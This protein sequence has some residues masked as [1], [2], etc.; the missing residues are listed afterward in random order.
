MI[1]FACLAYFTTSA[2]R[3]ELSNPYLVTRLRMNGDMP[4]LPICL[5]D[6]HTDNINFTFW[7]VTNNS[8]AYNRDTNNN[9]LRYES[10]NE[11]PLSNSKE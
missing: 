1:D 3:V 9:L 10:Y 4:P 11:Y 6:V 5:H 8:E 7:F 2:I